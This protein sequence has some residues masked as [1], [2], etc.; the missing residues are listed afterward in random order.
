MVRFTSYLTWPRMWFD[1]QRDV[2][3]ELHLLKKGF[4]QIAAIKAFSR[5]SV[6]IAVADARTID[7]ATD[8]PAR[9]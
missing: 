8:R 4:A 3:N 5:R 2:T 9:P 6:C 7:F 1:S